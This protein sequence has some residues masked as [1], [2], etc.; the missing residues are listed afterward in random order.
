MCATSGLTSNDRSAEL[1]S[2]TVFLPSARHGP[3]SDR[4]LI[5]FVTGNPGCIAYY[6]TFLTLLSER[7]QVQTLGA[8]DIVGFSLAN[9][10]DG[11]PINTGRGWQVLGLEEQVQFVE[12]TLLERIRGLYKEGS[13]SASNPVK[14]ILLGHSVGA[15]I[16][17]EIVRRWQ[18]K[19]SAE[20]SIVS[21]IGCIGLWPTISDLANSR[22]GRIAKVA[23]ACHPS[24]QY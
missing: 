8:I 17:L 23:D 7:L 21:F 18:K 3:P 2:R 20:S 13:P 9:F 22:S 4:V 15:Y 1:S 16:S 12:A 10:V 6:H 5:C 19:L 24:C 14:V 11:W